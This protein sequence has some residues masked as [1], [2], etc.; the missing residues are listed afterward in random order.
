HRPTRSLEAAV[1]ARGGLHAL[2][3][4]DRL[5]QRRGHELV[6][7]RWLAALDENRGVA[8]AAEKLVEFLVA[9]ARQHAGVGVLVAVEV[10]N[11]EHGSVRGRVE[12]LVRMPAGGER[13]GLRLTVTN[14]RGHD[15]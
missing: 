6:H 3:F 5:V 9:D 7:L 11:G 8:V 14:D 10:Q 13:A 1:A 2:N 15:K 4:A 12:K